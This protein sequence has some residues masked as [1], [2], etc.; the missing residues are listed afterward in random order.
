MGNKFTVCT[1]RRDE[2]AAL[3]QS[4]HC[5]FLLLII[6][7]H[8]VFRHFL[9]PFPFFTVTSAEIRALWFHFK[10]ISS[11]EEDDGIIDRT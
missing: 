5:Q 6:I 2:I 8:L 3:V 4:T 11:T 1:L 9:S 10:E 7:S